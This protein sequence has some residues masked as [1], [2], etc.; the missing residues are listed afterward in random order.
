MKITNQKLYQEIRTRGL[1]SWPGYTQ[2]DEQT[3]QKCEKAL[4]E[5][6]KPYVVKH[7]FFEELKIEIHPSFG[8]K[9]AHLLTIGDYELLDM[10]L[11]ELYLRK[12]ERILELGGGMGLTAAFCAMKTQAQV[13]VVE[14]N[15]DL[16]D[17]IRRQFAVNQVEKFFSIEQTCAINRSGQIPFFLHPELWRST[18]FPD[19]TEKYKKVMVE[20]KSLQELLEEHPSEVLIVD[21]EG[22]ETELFE[23]KVPVCVKKL[24][25]EIHAPN[26]PETKFCKVISEVQAQGFALKDFRNWM[27]Y[28]E[29]FNAL[30]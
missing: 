20:T 17:I 11:Y 3:F 19:P 24:F 13:H 9:I 1:L 4:K 16:S 6:P 28:F 10:E 23:S 12:G 27:F 29:R 2:E 14:P 8:G 26:F 21:I 22:G 18:L 25:V 30:K 7:P 15:A 5:N